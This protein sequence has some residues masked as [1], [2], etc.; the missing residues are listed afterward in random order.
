MYKLSIFFLIVFNLFSC[1]SRNNNNADV[2][3]DKSMPVKEI[4]SEIDK[5]IYRYLSGMETLGFSGANNVSMDDDILLNNGYGFADRETRHHYT[6]STIKTCGSVTKQFTA[7]AI[8]LL[9][10]HGQLPVNDTITKYFSRVPEDKNHH[11]IPASYTF[12]QFTGRHRS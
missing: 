9:E 5:N 6:S 3:E 10:S 8:L 12:L 4:T 11:Y 1:T 7:A 2:S